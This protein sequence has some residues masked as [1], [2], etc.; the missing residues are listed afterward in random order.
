MWE[1]KWWKGRKVGGER[2]KWYHNQIKEDE[3]DSLKSSMHTYTH[4]YR[5]IVAFNMAY[6]WNMEGGF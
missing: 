6:E 4:T 3:K 1:G 5:E 2:L